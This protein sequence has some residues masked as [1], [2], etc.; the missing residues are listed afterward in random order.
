MGGGREQGPHR[1]WRAELGSDAQPEDL[2]GTLP[3][4]KLTGAAVWRRGHFWGEVTET[5]SSQL[6]PK[7]V[8]SAFA[9]RTQQ[10][11]TLAG[12]C[13]R[14]GPLHLWLAPARRR[15]VERSTSFPRR[16][17][18]Q[19]EHPNTAQRATGAQRRRLLPAV[20]PALAGASARGPS[21]RCTPP[22]GAWV[23]PR[24]RAGGPLAGTPVGR[25]R[26]PPASSTP[27]APS[28]GLE[29]SGGARPASRC[30]NRERATG[31]PRTGRR[32]ARA[33]VTGPTHP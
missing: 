11:Q 27:T 19:H 5:N 16:F 26:G 22:G 23:L 21:A 18:Q 12:P 3:A 9:P 20:H 32:P 4:H 10:K 6:G 30:R 15:A 14:L 1:L 8:F 17:L 31:T 29:P 25:G 13:L 7:E 33:A 2:P 24:G 28:P